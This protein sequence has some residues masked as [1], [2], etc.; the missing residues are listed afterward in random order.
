MW[1]VYNVNVKESQPFLYYRLNGN[2]V[3]TNVY[4]E[5]NPK[6]TEGRSVWT[7]NGWVWLKGIIT[8]QTWCIPN[9]FV[10]K[11]DIE[12]CF[13]EQIRGIVEQYYKDKD[14]KKHNMFLFTKIK[15]IGYCDIGIALIEAKGKL[16]DR[17]EK[18]ENY[19]TRINNLRVFL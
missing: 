9:W 3:L 10:N 6:P 12:S 18:M 15:Q 7:K 4:D 17:N 2:G 19:I 11:E 14:Y 13:E 16:K 8:I 5:K 1:K